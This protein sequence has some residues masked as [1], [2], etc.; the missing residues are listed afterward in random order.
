MITP[1]GTE[2]GHRDFVCANRESATDVRTVTNLGLAGGTLNSLGFAD[3]GEL[4]EGLVADVVVFDPEEISDRATFEN[5]HQYSVGMRYVMVGGELVLD[6]GR[7]TGARP[8][9]ILYGPGRVTH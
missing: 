4:R 8:G 5:P 6:D 2:L 7:H 9:R 1:K 3:R